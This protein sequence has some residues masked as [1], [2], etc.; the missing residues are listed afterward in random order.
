MDLRPNPY[1]LPASLRRRKRPLTVMTPARRLTPADAPVFQAGIQAPRIVSSAH[2][3][4]QHLLLTYPAYAAG[5]YSYRAVYTDLLSQLPATTR[6][7]V[8]A[9]ASVVS[10]LQ[11]ALTAAGAA[12]RT[13]VVT[14]PD[15]LDFTVWAEDPYVAITDT[16]T[17][18]PFL[19][20]PF[21]FTRDGDGMLADLVAQTAEVKVNRSPLC[22]Q[23][24]NVLIGDD[25]VLIGADYPAETLDYV[26][27]YEAILIAED[28]DPKAAIKDLYQ[29]SFDPARKLIYISTDQPLPQEDTHK[30]QVNGETWQEDVYSWTGTNQPIFHIDMFLSLAGRGAGGKYR[31]LV[32][33]PAEAARL[34]NQPVS[35]FA[36]QDAYDQ[37]AGQLA[38][39]GF[40][41][42]RNPLPLT[43]VDDPEAKL[44]T[45]YMATAN[46]CLVQITEQSSDVW[47]PT[48]GHANWADLAAVDAENRRIW[49]ELGFTVHEL[50]DY[51]PFAQN[52]GAVHC[53]KKYIARG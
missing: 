31:V 10:D 34:L 50:G 33:S 42:I 19:L 45:W 21:L 47:L 6:Y 15:Y 46:N 8:V 4:M 12:D 44:R 27:K 52:L 18:T 26:K 29:Q 35:P 36:L 30:T 39:Q 3:V 24:G 49:Q 14:A 7:T 28:A 25:F 43:Y 11:A 9:H 41:V 53:I 1:R 37:I 13:T 22:F 5:E 32:G 23:G 48:Y 40:D 20:E 38:A 17:G 2:G 51:H 16:A